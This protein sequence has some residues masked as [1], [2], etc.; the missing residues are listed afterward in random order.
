MAVTCWIRTMSPQRNFS[1]DLL[2]TV[3][4]GLPAGLS[5]IP[6]GSGGIGTRTSINQ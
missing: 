1:D 4:D 5:C 6:P 3:N 2:I